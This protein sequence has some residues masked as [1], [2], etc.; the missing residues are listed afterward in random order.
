MKRFNLQEYLANPSQK[1]VTRDGKPVRILCTD[2]KGYYPIVGLINY[3]HSGEREVPENYTENGSCYIDN[4][5]SSSDLFFAPKQGEG[6]VNIYKIA[7]TD[8]IE[9]SCI[10]STKEEAEFYRGDNPKYVSTTKIT[11]EE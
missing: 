2:A 8:Q 7:D 1:V 9:A 5:E 6:W 11:W 3:P 10:F 4:D